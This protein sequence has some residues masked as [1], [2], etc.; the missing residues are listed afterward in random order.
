MRPL[1]SYV[2]PKRIAMRAPSAPAGVPVE[3]PE[4]VRRWVRQAGQELNTAG[5]V[6]VTFVIDESGGLR[7]ADRRSEH[8]T[9]AGGRSIRSAGE[10]AFTV[11]PNGVSVA[12][13]TNQSAGYCPEPDTW[14]A[15]EAALAR[16]G[17]TPPDGFSQEFIFRRCPQ[18]RSINIVKEGI[19]ECSVCSTPL[20][21]AWNLDSEA[22]ADPSQHG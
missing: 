21:E 1:Y 10:M 17:I 7:I 15:V 20:P 13:V 2:G 11:R 8:V 9:C 5:N 6:I 18:C 12:W 4:D 16:A 3:S 19:L 22:A 14:P